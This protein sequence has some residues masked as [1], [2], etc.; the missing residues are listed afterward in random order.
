MILRQV[1]QSLRSGKSL[2]RLEMRAVARGLHPIVADKSRAAGSRLRHHHAHLLNEC[3]TASTGSPR[4]SSEHSGAVGAALTI[5]EVSPLRD[6]R[7]WRDV[8]FVVS[9]STA[10]KVLAIFG[11]EI[12]TLP[13]LF[14]A[15]RAS[16][17]RAARANVGSGPVCS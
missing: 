6:L 7:K 11:N 9:N 15:D 17:G 14:L 4:E 10:L 16:A 5:I 13:I 3:R 1:M 12:G 2:D 8:S